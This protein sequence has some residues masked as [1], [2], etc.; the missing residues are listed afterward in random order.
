MKKDKK[1][2]VGMFSLT[3][4]EGCYF[5]VID[6]REKFLAL[7][8]KLEF[9]NFRLMEEGQHL[10]N[11]KYDIALVEGSPLTQDNI[12][13]LKEIR[14]NANILVAFGSCA[15]MGGI[16]HMK[17]YH[18]K[19]KI[20]NHVYNGNTGIDNLEVKPINQIVQVDYFIPG[21]PINA[22]EFL[23]IV[24]QLI[25][26]KKPTINQRPVCFECQ[27]RG[28]ECLLQKGQVCLGPITLGGCGAICLK[29]KQGCWGCRGLLEDAEVENLIKKLR[30]KYTDR[31]IVKFF[32]VF[33][34]KELINK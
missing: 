8:A 33:G 10:P 19:E 22:K 6:L 24:Y 21:C 18:D 32:E 20:F 34:I 29:S 31:Q 1:I 11:E 7:G 27:T 16:Y 17:Q 14:K 26:N 23:Q 13:E 3:G 4:C 28:F 2:R 15:C 12:S 30:E 5:S 25:I 9:V